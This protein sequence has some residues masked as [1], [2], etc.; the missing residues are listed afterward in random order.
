M[1]ASQKNSEPFDAFAKRQ[2]TLKDQAAPVKERRIAKIT[3]TKE[4]A[5][6]PAAGIYAAVDLV[7][8]FANIDRHCGYI[9]LYQSDARAPF[10]VTRREDNYMTNDQ[11]HQIELKRSQKAV[12][13]TWAQ[14]ARYC[15]NYDEH[16]TK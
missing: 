8:R 11:A 10:L 15:P 6:A 2:S 4:P 1:E 9:V 14:L 7:S 5:L 16:T 3:W 13:E 12:D